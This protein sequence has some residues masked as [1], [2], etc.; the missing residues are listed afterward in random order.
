MFY[1]S[2]SIGT[3]LFTGDARFNEKMTKN[4]IF[5]ENKIDELIFD[6]TYCNENFKFPSKEFVT[7]Q[8]IN[9]IEK[10]KN[11]NIYIA[12]G[13]LGKEY[14]VKKINEVFNKKIVVPEKKFMQLITIDESNLKYFTL[15]HEES[16]I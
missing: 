1:I 10:Y 5:S 15:N 13:A 14:L 6:N 9:L 16:N 8:I 11:K 3:F 7:D 12:I 2:G 4:P